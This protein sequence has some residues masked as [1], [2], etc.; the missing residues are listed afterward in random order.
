[1]KQSDLIK[2]ALGLLFAYLVFTMYNKVK[3]CENCKGCQ[4]NGCENC[5]ECQDKGCGNCAG[6]KH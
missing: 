6:C 1:M 5:K 2:V 3:G 4:S